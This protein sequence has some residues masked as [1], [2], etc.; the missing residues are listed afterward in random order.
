M[1]GF[2]CNVSN[3]WECLCYGD[4]V[5]SMKVKIL[6]KTYVRRKMEPLLKTPEC[7]KVYVPVTPKGQHSNSNSWE[8]RF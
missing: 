6:P 1:Q 3:S 4:N 5:T 8:D 7:L 2:T